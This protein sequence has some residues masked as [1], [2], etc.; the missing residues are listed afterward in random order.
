[1]TVSEGEDFIVVAEAK[2]LD[3]EFDVGGHCGEVEVFV[4]G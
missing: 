2:V 1:M 3:W 4:V